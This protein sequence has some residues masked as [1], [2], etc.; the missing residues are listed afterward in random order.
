MDADMSRAPV[1]IKRAYDWPAEGDGHRVLVDGMWPRGVRK[2]DAAIHAWP[3]ELAPSKSLRQWFGHDPDR[4]D[5]FRACFREELAS[6]DA[7]RA[8]LERLNEQ[9]LETPVTLVYAARNRDCNNAVVLQELLTEQ[10]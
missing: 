3:R 10:R 2:A 6:S 7:A 5:T 8:E 9:R 1:H 4:F